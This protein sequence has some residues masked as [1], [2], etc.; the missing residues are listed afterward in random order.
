VNFITPLAYT[1]RTRALNAGV[2]ASANHAAVTA[3]VT[4][5]ATTVAAPVAAPLAA[6]PQPQALSSA[7]LTNL[8]R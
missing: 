5:P 4:G 2:A 1:D 8:L 7:D 6:I 3:T